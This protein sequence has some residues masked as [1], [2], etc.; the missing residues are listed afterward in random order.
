MRKVSFLL[1][2]RLIERLIAK[3]L[4][5]SFLDKFFQRRKIKITAFQYSTALELLFM[6]KRSFVSRYHL[7]R[8]IICITVSSVLL[9][10]QRDISIF[11]KGWRTLGRKDDWSNPTIRQLSKNNFW[12][13]SNETFWLK[14][15][16]R[17]SSYSAHKFKF[18]L[19]IQFRF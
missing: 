3:Y 10:L 17:R 6:R 1:V 5:R 16:S 9:S 2:F 4:V 19:E 8:G 13:Q 15:Y 14:I 11:L 18:S 12:S 7:Y